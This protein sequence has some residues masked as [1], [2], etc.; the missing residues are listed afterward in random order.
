MVE[1]ELM[2]EFSE[3]GFVFSE[4][5]LENLK[6]EAD[7]VKKKHKVG[8][9]FLISVEGEGGDE[10]DEYRAWIKKPDLK[11][12][13]MFTKLVQ[14]DAVQAIKSVLNTCFLEGDIEIKN[15]DDIFIGAM[16]QM[17]EIMRTRQSKIAKF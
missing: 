14:K 16:G 10:K 17:E 2:E 1:E 13:S 9:V 6:A 8:K 7:K 15:D 5:E 4:E 12:V 11:T 3:K